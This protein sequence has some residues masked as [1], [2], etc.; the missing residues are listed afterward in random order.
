MPRESIQYADIS[1]DED[2]TRLIEIIAFGTLSFVYIPDQDNGG[3]LFSLKD[4][5]SIVP[6]YHEDGCMIFLRGSQKP[7]RVGPSVEDISSVMSQHA[8]DSLDL[9][10]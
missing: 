5:V 10:N 1:I 4:I 9:I 6:N 8:F 2:M 7:V 3:R